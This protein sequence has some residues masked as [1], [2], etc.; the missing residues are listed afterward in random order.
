[1]A[2]AT[3]KRN[4]DADTDTKSI[5][6]SNAIS[7][8]HPNGNSNRKPNLYPRGF[9]HAHCDSNCDRNTAALSD[10]AVSCDA[11]PSP[12]APASAVNTD[13]RIQEPYLA[14]Y[15]GKAIFA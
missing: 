10:T 6:D 9:A 1:M 13:V 8:S 5:G 15:A 2:Q 14:V 3:G 7:D 12:D 4:T 11:A